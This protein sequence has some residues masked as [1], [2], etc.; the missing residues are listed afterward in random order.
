MLIELKCIVVLASVF[1][2]CSRQEVVI[3]TCSH[4]ANEHL[5]LIA[6]EY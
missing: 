1:S 6:Y 4:F 3:H 2:V 5:H